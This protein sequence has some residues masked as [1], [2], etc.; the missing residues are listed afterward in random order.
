MRPAACTT[1][2]SSSIFCS[3]SVRARGVEDLLAHD[4]PLH[5]VG[6]EVERDLGEQGGPS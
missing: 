4:R 5:V 3:V 6:A 1:R 2:T